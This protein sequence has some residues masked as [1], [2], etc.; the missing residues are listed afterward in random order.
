MKKLF[1]VFALLC[2]FFVI[3]C[4]SGGSKNDGNSGEPGSGEAVTDEDSSDSDSPDNSD[5]VITDEDIPGG[6]DDSDTTPEQPDNGGLTHDED[7]DAA[8]DNGDSADDSDMAAPDGGDSQNDDDSDTDTSDSGSDDGSELPPD[9]QL[10][11]C[12]QTSST[13]CIDWETWLIWSGKAAQKMTWKEA[14]SYCENLNEGGFSDWRLPN[15][16]TL[17]T[18]R[19]NC[20]PVLQ[21]GYDYG[22][23][24]DENIEEYYSKFGETEIFWSSSTDDKNAL[25]VY[26]HNGRTTSTS[27]DEN[28]DVRCV[29]IETTAR[30]VNCFGFPADE[31]VQWNSVSRIA[32]TWDWTKAKWLPDR[33]AVFNDEAST[34]ECR[35]NCKFSN[36]E[37]SLGWQRCIAFPY[38]DPES[39]LTWSLKSSDAKNWNDAK[40]YCENLTEGG[41]SDWRLPS[42]NDLRNLIQNCPKTVLSGSCAVRDPDCLERSCD[43]PD[44]SEDC[45]CDGGPNGEYT[46]F[47]KYSKLGIEDERLWSSS[48][49]AD[50]TKYAWYVEFYLALIRYNDIQYPVFQVRCVR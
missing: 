38:T 43:N 23:K 25:G 13:P 45:A 19:Q 24:E 34:T 4:G 47:A 17:R 46:K 11:K 15:I 20:N 16:A 44:D 49:R 40:S 37:W 22:C 27:R 7:A 18:L 2:T 26:F 50:D 6:N 29:R 9:S 30:D 14:G 33:K 12:S 42:I 21:L 32:Q 10:P 39:G 48:L 31:N 28:Y 41:Y 1:I 35:F 3:S 5:T 36:Y 8:P